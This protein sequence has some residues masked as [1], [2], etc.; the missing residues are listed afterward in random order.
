MRYM[1]HDF[2]F[3]KKEKERKKII[4]LVLFLCFCFVFMLLSAIVKESVSPIYRIFLNRV[5]AIDDNI[6]LLNICCLCGIPLAT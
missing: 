2:F 4:I 1:S 5:L 3:K 6:I